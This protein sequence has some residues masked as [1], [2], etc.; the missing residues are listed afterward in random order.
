M[1]I[2]IVQEPA[3]VTA[4]SA[5]NISKA[6]TV[7]VTAG[8]LI[9]VGCVRF[10]AGSNTAF[11]AG[12]CTKSAGTATIGT[13]ALDR[14]ANVGTSSAVQAGVWSVPVT[15]SGSL[16]IQVAGNAASYF[17]LAVGEYSGLDV[18]SSRVDG[19]PS[20]NTSLTPTSPATS[21]NIT[22][23]GDALFF[24]VVA[25]DSDNVNTAS[26]VGNS[27]TVLAQAVNGSATV[28][29]EVDRRIVTGAATTQGSWTWTTASGRGWAAVVV[30]YKTAAGGGGG[31][32][33][34]MLPGLDGHSSAGPKQFNP[35]LYH[36]HPAISLEAY[37]RERARKHRDFLA[38]V[39][40]A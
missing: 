22:S 29:G 10:D 13:I 4:Q 2:A 17:V 30:A 37:Q 6:F 19:T 14:Q 26:V 16:T 5:S 7:N 8:N 35:T 28:P 40:V 32:T 25:I 15:G 20:G 34:F 3:G 38:K 27:F 36:R 24:A 9:V 23:T 31:R 39:R 18:S 11:V 33:F 1:T 12:D 21:G